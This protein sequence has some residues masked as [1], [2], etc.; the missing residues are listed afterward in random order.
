MVPQPGTSNQHF[1][2][3]PNIYSPGGSSVTE[4]VWVF[5]VKSIVSF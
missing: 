1:R 3:E 4:D 2:E 5:G